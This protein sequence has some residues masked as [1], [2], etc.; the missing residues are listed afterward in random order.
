MKPS[1]FDTGDGGRFNMFPLLPEGDENQGDCLFRLDQ[2]KQTY[3]FVGLLAGGELF[4]LL[5]FGWI[6]DGKQHYKMRIRNDN[7]G[8]KYVFEPPTL[9]HAVQ[10]TKDIADVSPFDEQPQFFHGRR[11]RQFVKKMLA[12]AVK[13]AKEVE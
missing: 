8:D 4:D 10:I 2:D 1:S 12:T 6:E 3:N 9:D 13:A 7:T 11:A 5:G